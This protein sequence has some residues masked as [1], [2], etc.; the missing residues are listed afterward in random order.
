L[1]TQEWTTVDASDINRLQALIAIHNVER[2]VFSLLESL[3][4]A[5]ERLDSTVMHKDV[6][7]L[8]LAIPNGN[9]AVTVNVIEP[10]ADTNILSNAIVV[11]HLV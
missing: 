5:V 1:I 2:H 4:L 8:L 10:L 7:A 11:S 9:E 6:L 3:I